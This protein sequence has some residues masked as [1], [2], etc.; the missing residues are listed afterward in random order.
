MTRRANAIGLLAAAALAS[1]GCGGGNGNGDGDAT[2]G[3]GCDQ[4]KAD[5]N[6]TVSTRDRLFVDQR[7]KD[8]I[9]AC[10]GDYAEPGNVEEC[11][12]ARADLE[13][14]AAAETPPADLEARVESA[15]AA[16]VD[17]TITST[18]PP[19]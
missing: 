13:E 10:A 19:P 14:A 1:A 3:G 18:I 7:I 11:R 5:L 15:V 9:A 8:A 17:T 2:G 6:L 12:A 16:C 4:A